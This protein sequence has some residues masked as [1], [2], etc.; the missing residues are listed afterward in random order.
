MVIS[1]DFIIKCNCCGREYLISPEELGIDYAYDECSMG[2]EIQHIFC[3]ETDCRCGEV[4]CYKITAVEYPPGAY[5]FHMNEL[6]NCF[7]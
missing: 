7:S 4:L 2:T 5:S 6:E 1:N 3:G